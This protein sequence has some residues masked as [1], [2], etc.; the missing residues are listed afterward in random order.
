MDQ[1]KQE[2]EQL[3]QTIQ[4]HS[5]RYYVQDAPTI[6]DYEYD[7]LMQ[8]LKQIEAEHPELI[9]EDSPT[10]RVGGTALEQFEGHT[11]PVPLDSLQDVFSKEEVF[12]FDARV[13]EVVENPTYVVECKIDGLSVSLEYEDGKLVRGVTRGDG[14]TGEVVTQNIRTIRSI[15]MSIPNAPKRLI[16]RGEVYMPREVFLQLNEQRE[17]RGEALFANPRNAAAGSL[18]QLDPKIAAERKLDIIVFNM[19]LADGLEGI[20]THRQ[21]LDYLASLGFR[22]SPFY[23]GFSTIEDAFDEVLRLGEKRGDLPFQ[24]DGAVIKVDDLSQRP[25]LGKTSKFP[26][27]AVAYKYPPEQKQT[28]LRDIVIQ[29]GRTGVLTPNAVLEP[30]R[31]AGVTVSRATLHN[32]DFIKER[33]IHIGDTVVVQKAG[34]IIPEIVRVVK[35]KRPSDAAPFEMPS[36]CPA[37]GAP[38][39][40]EEGEAA[41]RCQ[42]ATCP[43]Q[44][45]RNIIHFASRG[46]MDIEGLGPALVDLLVSEDLVKSPADLYTLRLADVAMLP[47][48]GQKSAQNLIDAIERSKENDLGKL[49]FALGIRHV[50][51]KTAKVISQYFGTMDEISKASEEELCA[52]EDVGPAIAHSMVNWFAT[53]DEYLQRLRDTGLNMNDISEV[54]DDRFAGSVFVLTGS[55]SAFTRDEASEMI[56]RLGGKVASSV[57][58]KTS[59]VVAGENAGSKLTKAQEL[60]IT[61]LS[62]QDFLQLVGEESEEEEIQL[63]F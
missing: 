21:S 15:P 49:L 47:R 32:R 25:L 29:V 5:T 16:V 7:M 58:K 46:A 42:S 52:I 30:V 55:L 62:E 2:L 50:G 20:Q 9:T 13:R 11:H 44:I 18:R 27:W 40:Q 17:D 26:K 1:I 43:A 36:V 57:S 53:A 60:G 56:T 23:Q 35:E 59:F 6:S 14:V 38:V 4:E 63:T 3:K 19:Q 31:V 48:M 8:R 41:V 37:C 22:T 61:V 33:D 45:R 39:Y 34:D 12:A 54:S 28:V 24:I 51:Q 10:Q